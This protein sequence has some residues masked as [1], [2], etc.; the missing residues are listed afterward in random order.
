MP[1]ETAQQNHDFAVS[2][3]RSILGLGIEPFCSPISQI[4]GVS[5]GNEGVQWNIAIDKDSGEV[6]LGVNLEGMKYDGWPIA[7][8]IERELRDAKLLSLA[9]TVD[10]ATAI[11]VRFF[12]DAWRFSV[13]PDTEQKWISGGQVS[14]SELS[15]TRW[16]L[17]L[18]E[19]YSCLDPKRNHRGR[20]KQT[21][22]LMNGVKKEMWVSPHLTICTQVWETAPASQEAASLLIGDRIRLLTPIYNL[23]TGQAQSP[24][25]PNNR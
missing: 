17:M 21:V 8:F 5:D 18:E 6:W 15:P 7:T 13:R 9:R 11:W 1:S 25:A 19:A 14:L 23:V 20:V 3:F 24:A 12:R 2:V 22:T 4:Y 10:D 16:R